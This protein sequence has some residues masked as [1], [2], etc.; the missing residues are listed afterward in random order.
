METGL[1]IL[2]VLVF[3]GLVWAGNKYRNKKR[4]SIE[5]PDILT[6]INKAREPRERNN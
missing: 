2:G 4:A 3:L 5:K 1:T 6:E